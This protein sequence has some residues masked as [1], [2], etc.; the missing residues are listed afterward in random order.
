MISYT[1]NRLVF[2]T[3]DKNTVHL[4]DIEKMRVSASA[5]GIQ[6]KHGQ[7]I[8]WS[9][10]KEIP[11]SDMIISYC[12][13]WNEAANL[14]LIDVSKG[15]L[16]EIFTFEEFHGEVGYE[17]IAYS[18]KRNLLALIS[19]KSKISYHL[20]ERQNESQV[21]LVQ[22]AKWHSQHATNNLSAID[23][24][25]D[26]R[27][28]ATTDHKGTCLISELD[29]QAYLYHKTFEISNEDDCVCQWSPFTGSNLLYVQYDRNQLNIL[30]VEKKELIFEKSV[31]FEKDSSGYIQSMDVC[32][33]YPN[34]LALVGNEQTLNIFDQRSGTVVKEI[35]PKKLHND[36]V[37]C[38]RWDQ[39]GATLATCSWDRTA[40]LI[41]FRAEKALLQATSSDGHVVCSVCILN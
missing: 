20:F 25:P 40:K 36:Q 1:P 38:V 32:P 15:T 3:Y 23:I 9:H 27:L 35:L 39:A 2:S 24:N 41:D 34:L 6:I 11:G 5:Q 13:K 37:N 8:P 29:S 22:K 16:K 14:Q 26:G 17:D 4:Y 33:N 30:D 19:V 21:S 7:G 12:V 31:V 18:P 28:V 10:V